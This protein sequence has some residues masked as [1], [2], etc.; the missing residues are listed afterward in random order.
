MSVLKVQEG[1]NIFDV[2]LQEFGELEQLG[3]FLSDNTALTI[4]DE[5]FSGQEVEINSENIGDVDVKTKYTRLNFITNNKDPNFTA[6]FQDQKQFQNGDAFDFMNG[7]AF[8][9]N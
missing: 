6:S 4:N 7:D 9:Y 8:E 2:V 5:L 3:L 1:Q